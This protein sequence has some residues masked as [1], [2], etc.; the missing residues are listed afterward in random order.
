MRARRA[1]MRDSRHWLWL[2]FGRLGTRNPRSVMP[3]HCAANGCQ[4]S[5]IIIHRSNPLCGRNALGRSEREIAARKRL[6][7]KELSPQKAA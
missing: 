4:L 3:E 5:V 2:H 6:P 7:L 1:W